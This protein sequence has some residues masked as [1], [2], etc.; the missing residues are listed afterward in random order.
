VLFL[1]CFPSPQVPYLSLAWA[2]TWLHDD[3]VPTVKLQARGPI[4]GAPHDSKDGNNGSTQ[5][6]SGVNVE[7]PAVDDHSSGWTAI[8]SRGFVLGGSSNSSSKDDNGS[9]ILGSKNKKGKKRPA[10]AKEDNTREA[11]TLWRRQSS[12]PPSGGSS[13]RGKGR[14]RK[15]LG[16][17]LGDSLQTCAALLHLPGRSLL[18]ARSKRGD[19]RRSDLSN[20]YGGDGYEGGSGSRRSQKK[21]KKTSIEHHPTTTTVLEVAGASH[22]SLTSDPGSLTVSSRLYFQLF[23]F[24]WPR[25]LQFPLLLSLSPN[26]DAF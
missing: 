2:H 10:P 12:G 13:G 24:L 18:D 11:R 15:G 17:A 3:S 26:K 4:K 16:E 14:T 6:R 9:G 19:D 8:F 23:I 1:C 7:S 22:T 20:A 25:F 21:E 5:G